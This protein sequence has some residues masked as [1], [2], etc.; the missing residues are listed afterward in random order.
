MTIFELDGTHLTRQKS[1]HFNEVASY[2]DI[3]G[4]RGLSGNSIEFL[5]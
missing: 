1:V 5:Y 3:N 2:H 4:A